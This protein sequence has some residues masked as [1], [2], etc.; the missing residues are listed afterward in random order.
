MDSHADG[1]KRFQKV[2]DLLRNPVIREDRIQRRMLRTLTAQR[3][4]IFD[5][6]GVAHKENY[7]SRLIAYLLDPVAEHDQ[8]AVFLNSFLRWLAEKPGGLPDTALRHA[9][10]A[11]VQTE[12]HAEEDGRID[13]V[14]QLRDGTTIAIENKIN[15]HESERQLERYWNWLRRRRMG[16]ENLRLIFLTP[17]GR[18]GITANGN[19]YVRMSYAD[20]AM[21]LEDGLADCPET[22]VSLKVTVNQY[23]R[24]CHGIYR[25]AKGS[26]EMALEN[27]KITELLQD[28]GNLA[29]A[30]DVREHLKGVLDTIKKSFR[31]NVISALDQKLKGT[32]AERQ[33][34]VGIAVQNEAWLGL[35]PRGGHP[36]YC[37]IAELKFDGAEGYFGWGAPARVRDG[38]S[39]VAAEIQEKLRSIGL[40]PDLWWGWVGW[41]DLREISLL[42][43]LLDWDSDG[44][45]RIH[46]D[47]Q[48][49][50]HD[51]ADALADVIW[52]CFKSC[53]EDFQ[54]LPPSFAGA[55]Q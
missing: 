2:R 47:N 34:T 24:L 6:L 55:V 12:K 18:H 31:E 39:P 4:N 22:A 28:S 11:H 16:T 48:G 15:H 20:L 32:A 5:A 3:H 21:V 52:S 7:H 27:K 54:K 17:D 26:E 46:L 53:Y 38:S 36:G 25:A 35:V 42:R 19:E 30:L 49:E 43:P 50:S 10:T 13:L 40:K 44:I 37:C 9:V 1:E 29:A 33:W 51:L 14:I 45:L 23:V 41:A 8:G